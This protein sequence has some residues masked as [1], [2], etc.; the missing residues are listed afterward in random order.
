MNY[1]RRAETAVEPP[2]RAPTANVIVAKK[3]VISTPA[4]QMV[5]PHG[6]SESAI[7]IPAPA[8]LPASGLDRATETRLKKGK[9]APDARLDLH[10]MTAA[11]AHSAL[12]GFIERSRVTGK[13]CVLIITG[14][15]GIGVLRRDTPLWLA[16]PPLAHQIV[17]VTPAHAR[18]GGG[19]ALYVYLKRIR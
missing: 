2:R 6:R 11:A 7:T 15:G 17:N 13:R 3:P 8:A 5:R 4:L 18:H 1:R 9:R 16:A 19:G 12:I 14:K 10:G